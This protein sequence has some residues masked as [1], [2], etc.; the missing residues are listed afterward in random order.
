MVDRDKILVQAKAKL[1]NVDKWEIPFITIP[2][3]KPVKLIV[4][5]D[6]LPK[7]SSFYEVRYE[8]IIDGNGKV[9][10]QLKGIY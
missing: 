2:I 1:P 4:D 10:W 9:I 5:N 6:Y 8:K 3:F 7:E